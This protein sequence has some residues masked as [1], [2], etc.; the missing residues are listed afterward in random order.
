M[1]AKMS[2]RILIRF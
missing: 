1:T 2:P